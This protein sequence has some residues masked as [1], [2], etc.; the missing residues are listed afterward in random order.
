M[1]V[2]CV[3]D[4]CD[5]RG[6]RCLSGTEAIAEPT[7]TRGISARSYVECNSLECTTGPFGATGATAAE[8]IAAW[9]AL[10]RP[11]P[12]ARWH[13]ARAWRP[14]SRTIVECPVCH[15]LLGVGAGHGVYA[16][17]PGC[18]CVLA[19]AYGGGAAVTETRV[20]EATFSRKYGTERI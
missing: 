4:E 19:T 18:L 9:N 13:D 12:E 1:R 8:A 20:C 10:M 17:C 16:T 11:R 3:S 7:V 14:A 15:V 6:P 5:S 2:S